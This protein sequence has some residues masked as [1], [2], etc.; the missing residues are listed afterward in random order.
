MLTAKAPSAKRSRT[1][2]SFA[3]LCRHGAPTSTRFSDFCMPRPTL[4]FALLLSPATAL[5]VPGL[6]NSREA[7]A[8]SQH[9]R[10][11]PPLLAGKR[12]DNPQPTLRQWAAAESSAVAPLLTLYTLHAALKRTLDGLGLG[13]PASIIGM[14]SGPTSS[15]NPNPNP[16][17]NPNPNPNPNPSS[18]PNLTPKSSQASG[19]SAR[20]ARGAP[21]RPMHSRPSSRRRAGCSARGLPPSSRPASLGSGSG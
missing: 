6:R 10:S 13:F 19:R 9:R 3:S 2:F 12:T 15:T 8:C 17:P 14:L 5:I 4:V 1:E 20:S 18:T 16:R 11:L 21:R 7:P